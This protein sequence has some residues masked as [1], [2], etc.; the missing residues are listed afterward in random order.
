[1][2]QYSAEDIFSLVAFEFLSRKGFGAL[3]A[4]NFPE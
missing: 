2:A 3:R 1:M 4:V